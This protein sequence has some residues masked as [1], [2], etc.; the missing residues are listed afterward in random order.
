MT[1]F[2]ETLKLIEQNKIKDS[3]RKPN[4]NFYEI[5]AKTSKTTN[6]Y[7]YRIYKKNTAWFGQCDC[8]IGISYNYRLCN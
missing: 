8:K 7:I 3:I 6:K 1:I 4:D 2:T 5:E